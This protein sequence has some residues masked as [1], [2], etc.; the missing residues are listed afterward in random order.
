MKGAEVKIQIVN[1]SISNR[2]MRLYRHG[3]DFRIT[4][5]RLQISRLYVSDVF[6]TI[7]AGQPS[8]AD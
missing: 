8:P 5:G 7:G 6:T 1:V 3:H 4:D 2:D